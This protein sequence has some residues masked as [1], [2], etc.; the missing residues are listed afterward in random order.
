MIH[1]T[2]ESGGRTTQAKGHDQ[3]LIV[4]LIVL[5]VVL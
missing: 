2:F 4:T 1:E 3:E 5:N